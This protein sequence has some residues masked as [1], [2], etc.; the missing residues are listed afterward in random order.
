MIFI[1]YC[2][3]NYF[4]HALIFFIHVLVIHDPKVEAIVLGLL[5]LLFNMYTFVELCF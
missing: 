3:H 2:G 1:D 5:R 4:I